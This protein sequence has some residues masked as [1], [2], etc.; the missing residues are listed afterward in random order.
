MVE[1]IASSQN[2][3]GYPF[4]PKSFY[5]D[6]FEDKDGVNRINNILDMKEPKEYY[7]IDNV[8]VSS[9]VK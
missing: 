8:F 6:V 3:K 4:E 5:I 7:N 1:N 2:I 9:V